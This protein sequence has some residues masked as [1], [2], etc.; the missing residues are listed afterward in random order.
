[1][2]EAPHTRWSA[3]IRCIP[4]LVA[5]T[6]LL[7]LPAH[8]AEGSSATRD[9]VWQIVNFALLIGVLV[10]FARKPIQQY[11]AG[12]REQIRSEVESGADLLKQA[13]GRFAEWQQKLAEIDSE[14]DEI[15]AEANRSARAE[16]DRILTDARAAADR[17]RRDARAAMEHEL[18]RAQTELRAEASDLATEFAEA[19]LREQV[20]DGDLER[21]V[22]EFISH[23]EHAP[24]GG[25]R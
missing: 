16:R 12:R 9:F 1:M 21:L 19:I 24:S 17:M 11:F 25:G 15:R 20:R 18:R 13:E 3:A 14:L 10:Y 8:A 4:G 2:S 5:L 23:V 22:D 7:G 6:M